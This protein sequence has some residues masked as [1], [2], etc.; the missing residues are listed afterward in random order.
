MLRE[1]T[2][3]HAHPRQPATPPRGRLVNTRTPA[4]IDLIR[5]RLTDADC[6]PR[7]AG[8]QTNARCPA[9]EDSTASLTLSEGRDGRVLL[10]CFAGCQ[11]DDVLR[12]LGLE[13]R[14]L[15]PPRDRND[16][17]RAVPPGRLPRRPPTLDELAADHPAW[18]AWRALGGT[19]ADALR[20][21]AA[22]GQDAT[23]DARSWIVHRAREA[24][25]VGD[26]DALRRL[27]E[28]LGGHADIG[29]RAVW[30]C[31]EV[32][33]LA[34]DAWWRDDREALACAVAVLD[35]IDGIA[36]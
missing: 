8:R 28:G 7:K 25:R 16:R 17:L 12:A 6:N 32:E 31:I 13:L 30:L 35:D 18:A 21:R 5:E 9:H 29:E 36:T 23:G 19:L 11:T 24:W 10:H 20:I 34:R 3:L 26:L 2:D 33:A 1:H 14:D 4:P 15:F 27:L 22:R